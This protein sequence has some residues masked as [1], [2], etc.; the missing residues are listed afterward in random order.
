MFWKIADELY[1]LSR[2][3]LKE[4]KHSIHF[5]INERA[6]HVW[7]EENGKRNRAEVGARI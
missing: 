3:A 1:A 7:I 4:T 6:I 5:E 2:K